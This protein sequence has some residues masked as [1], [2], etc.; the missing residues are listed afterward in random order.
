M[1]RLDLDTTYGCKHTGS[2]RADQ[3]T[4]QRPPSFNACRPCTETCK[5]ISKPRDNRLLI[6]L[7]ATLFVCTPAAGAP[8]DLQPPPPGCELIRKHLEPRATN[9]AAVSVFPPVQLEIRT[10]FEPTAFP[11]SGRTY[12]IYELHLRNFGGDALSLRGIEVADATGATGNAIARFEA[13]PLRAMLSPV[14]APAARES[15]DDSQLATGH[16]SIVFLCLAFDAETTVPDKLFHR[17]LVNETVVVGPLVGTAYTKMRVFGPPIS[18]PGWTAAGGPGNQSHHR[19]GLFVADGGA[20]LSRRYSID[21][22]KIRDGVRFSGDP[23]DVRSYHTYGEWVLAVDDATVLSSVDGL[24]D[25][26]PRTPGGFET[27]LPLT[28]ET[29]AGNAVVLDLGG[30]QFAYYAHLQPGS[31]QVKA[32]DR[33]HRGQVLGRI[34]N[35]GDSRSPHLHFQVTNAAG[36]MSS[37]GVPYVIDEYWLRLSDGTRQRRTRELPLQDALIDFE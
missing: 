2:I 11:S 17:V 23:L 4:V 37:E 28:M 14:G 18:G 26:V 19:V 32:G 25:N 33:V 16:S 1:P 10:P 5:L 7:L 6:S 31:V 35:S 29:I 15:M 3:C 9:A 34:G 12:L 13:E 20:H 22:L 21:W 36:L 27:A 8:A 24:P 30:E